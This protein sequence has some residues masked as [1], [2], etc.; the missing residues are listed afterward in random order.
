M[1]NNI[2][3]ELCGERMH[4]HNERFSRDKERLDDHEQRIKTTEEAVILLTSLQAQQQETESTLHKRLQVLENRPSVWWDR[5][6]G[7]AIAA[8]V[9]G[10]LSYVM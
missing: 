6:I 8:A 10:F 7:A 4:T 9:S 5:L 1:E 2:T 3:K